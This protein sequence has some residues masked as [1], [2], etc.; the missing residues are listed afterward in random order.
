MLVTLTVFEEGT[1]QVPQIPASYQTTLAIYSSLQACLYTRNRSIKCKLLFMVKLTTQSNISD[2]VRIVMAESTQ[3]IL[4][5]HA[6]IYY[7]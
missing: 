4:Q 2:R 1:P 3:L 6:Q 5:L 7:S